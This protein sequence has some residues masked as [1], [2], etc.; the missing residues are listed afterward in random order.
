MKRWF[1]NLQGFELNFEPKWFPII[2]TLNVRKSVNVVELA[3]EIRYTHPST[4]L[5]LKEFEKNKLIKSQKGK[6]D[7]RKCIITLS[8]K[9]K[10]LLD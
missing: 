6:V 7:Q 10:D 8:A 2:Y 3:N 4:I 1:G 5:L 9:G